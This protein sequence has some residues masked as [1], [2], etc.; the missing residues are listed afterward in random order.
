MVLNMTGGGGINLTVVG[1]TTVPASP[2]ENTI[3]VNTS[4]A[5]SSYVM[6]VT[7]PE[8]PVA[9]MVWFCYRSGSLAPI[10]VVKNSGIWAY[11]A[12]C[13]QYVNGAW[14]FK[15][16]SVYQSG[17]WI[18]LTITA[19]EPGKIVLPYYLTTTLNKNPSFTAGN[20][21]TTLKGNE[22][23]YAGAIFGPIDVT[24]FKTLHFRGGAAP[25]DNAAAILLKIWGG[26]VTNSNASGLAQIQIKTGTADY[27]LDISGINQTAY[28]GPTLSYNYSM[29]IY[30]LELR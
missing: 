4:T 2:K 26:R 11:P 28:F 17:K 6:S 1:G 14:V 22:G 30:E 29:T 7:E 21:Y 12:D 19:I 27:D 10:E 5:I 16:A 8:S 25:N 24:P 9:G 20:G 13:Q 3:W 23:G 18:S 15:P